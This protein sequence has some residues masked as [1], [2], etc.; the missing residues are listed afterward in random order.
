M[1]FNYPYFNYP[2]RFP[3][4]NYKYYNNY[5]KQN[6]ANQNSSAK[7]HIDHINFPNN[8]NNKSQKESTNS[9]EY[10]DIFGIKL[11]FD[12]ILL[13][14]LIYFLYTDGIKDMYLFFILVLLLLT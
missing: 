13:I 11:H 2:S 5:S 7:K 12:D 9:S 1:M 14:L 10:I 8:N 4:Y 6:S 3:N